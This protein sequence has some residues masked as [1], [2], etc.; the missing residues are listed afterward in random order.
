[1]KL[2]WIEIYTAELDTKAELNGCQI[3]GLK[4]ETQSVVER[5]VGSKGFM[6]ELN[7]HVI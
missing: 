4:A 1:M 6:R 5:D 3:E 2:T 7:L